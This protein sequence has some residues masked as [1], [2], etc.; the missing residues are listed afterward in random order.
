[1]I[2]DV[3][4]DESSDE[5]RKRYSSVGGFVGNGEQWTSLELQWMSRTRDL[6]KPFHYTNCECQHEEYTKWSKP[7]CDV[8]ITD[9]VTI[10]RQ[11]KIGGAGVFAPIPDLASVLGLGEDYDGQI[12]C[13]KCV[14]IHVANLAER[15]RVDLRFR[16]EENPATD[17]RARRAY[18]D[19]KAVKQWKA[20]R[21]MCSF[22]IMSKNVIGLQAADLMARETFKFADNMGSGRN[23]RKPLLRLDDL[24]SLY[25]WTKASLE[26][27]KKNWGTDDEALIRFITDVGSRPGQVRSLSQFN[28]PKTVS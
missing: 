1:M 23:I 17:G 12:F 14:F 16:L 4:L 8:L 9:L 27:L 26:E 2:H 5:R 28:Y 20:A 25:G 18:G 11:C 6:K 22:E 24:V 3:Y 19:L 13:L 21:R 10:A 15:H 7:E